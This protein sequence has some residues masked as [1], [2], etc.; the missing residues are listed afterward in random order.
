MIPFLSYFDRVTVK[1]I[2]NLTNWKN[3]FLD[4]PAPYLTDEGFFNL[5]CFAKNGV[6]HTDAQIKGSS[7]VSGDRQT[8]VMPNHTKTY[9]IGE[10]NN[11]LV[12]NNTAKYCNGPLKPNTVYV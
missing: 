7:S 5:P 12:E 2:Q 10:D 8:V 3:A 9:V 4:R 6:S 1:D 11:C